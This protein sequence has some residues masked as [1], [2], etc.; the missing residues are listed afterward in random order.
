[1]LRVR[2][3][4]RSWSVRLVGSVQAV[5]SDANNCPSHE[6]PHLW[7]S[8]RGWHLL[9]HD[10]NN[11]NL[12]GVRGAYAWSLDGHAWTLETPLAAN[13][14]A[15]SSD[16]VWANSTVRALARRQRPSFVRDAETNQPTHLI[17]GLVCSDLAS[18]GTHAHAHI[19]TC[20][21]TVL[22]A[23]VC[24]FYLCAYTMGGARC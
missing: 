13:T 14:S 4:I 24:S 17:T 10:Q 1:M 16:I 8:R 21:I 11:R 22:Y 9:T 18:S 7:F 6:D 3:L 5:C 20:T 15:W 23:F 12:H 2:P 19:Y